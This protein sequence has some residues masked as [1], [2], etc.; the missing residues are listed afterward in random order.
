MPNIAY[1]VIAALVGSIA[2]SVVVLPLD[3]DAGLTTIEGTVVGVH[4]NPH[5]NV[6]VE[7]SVNVTGDDGGLYEVELG[8]PW[9]WASV[10]LPGIEGD[11][12]LRVE[13]VLEDGHEIEAYTIWLNGGDAIVIR[14][15]GKP[16]WAEAASGKP[17]AEDDAE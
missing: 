16:A 17:K 15:A 14:E 7:Y 5:W 10:G 3:E 12:T 8:P 11:D 2:G 9:W 6:S 4:R 1:A 13:G